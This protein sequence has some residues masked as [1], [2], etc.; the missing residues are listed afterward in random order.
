M[1]Y[2]R[3]REAYNEVLYI[4]KNMKIEDKNRIS[5][6]FI[7]FLE[8]NKSDNYS[9]N[10]I[11]LSKPESLKR[12]TRTILSIMYREYFCSKEERKKL[13]EEDN[14]AISQLYNTDNLFSKKKKQDVTNVNLENSIQ[15]EEK[16]LT[17]YTGFKAFVNRLVNKIKNLFKK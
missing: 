7:D 14:K 6:G 9:I 8:K 11:S 17:Q 5:K 16:D 2:I 15:T 13:E 12:E 3:Y 1:E 10:N 4:I